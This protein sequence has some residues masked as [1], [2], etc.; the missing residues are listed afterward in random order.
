M[1]KKVMIENG[2]R[3]AKECLEFCIHKNLWNSIEMDTGVLMELEALAKTMN[4]KI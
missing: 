4:I 2:Q 1:T 3:V